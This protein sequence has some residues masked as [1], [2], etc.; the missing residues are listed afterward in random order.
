MQAVGERRRPAWVRAGRGGTGARRGTCAAGWGSG[1]RL[2]GLL[3]AVAGR[4]G[5]GLR[6]GKGR[7]ILPTTARYQRDAM[8]FIGLPGS[9]G[10]GGKTG[11]IACS[12]ATVTYSK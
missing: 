6:E 4:L 2:V 7:A 5:G 8:V 11:A 1:Q 10:R 12:R 9:G 3:R